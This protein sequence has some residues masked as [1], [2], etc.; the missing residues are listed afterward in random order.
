[1]LSLLFVPALYGQKK[2]AAGL[3]HGLDAYIMKVLQTF[4]VPGAGVAIVKD[5]KP[6]LTKGYG[7]KKMG[8]P[9]AVDELT[10]FAIASNSKA[11]TGT[12]LAMLAEEGKIKWDAPV[13]AYLPWFK[14]SD[15][16]ITSHLSV[17][18]LLVHHS[19]IPAYAGDLMLFPPSTYSRSEIIKRF[20]HIPFVNDFRTTYAYDN[21]LYLV[22]GEVITV[23]SGMPW[24]TFIK[25]RIFDKVGMKTSISKFSTFKDQP[26]ISAAHFRAEGKVKEIPDAY[27]Q[28]M[29]DAGNP[30]GGVL[31]NA[32]DMAQWMITQLDSGRTPL[33]K[34]LY[35]PATTNELW[36][37]VRPMPVGKV[38]ESILPSQANFAGYGLGFRSMNYGRYKLVYHGGKLDGFVSQV[39]MVPELNL[40]ITVLTNQEATGA[41]WSIIYQVLDHYMK[42][43]GF[44]W[45]AGYKKIQDTYYERL[46]N[47]QEKAVITKDP[48]AGPSLPVAKYMGTFRDRLCGDVTIAQSDKG[49]TLQFDFSPQ[50]IADVEHFQRD[51]FIAKFRN[52]DFKADAYL[53]YALNPD[54]TIAEL[55][56]QIIDPDSDLSF[57][58]LRLR[59][60]SFDS[61]ELRKKI[62]DVF[63]KSPTGTFAVAYKELQSGRTF[64][65]NEQEVFHAA[66]TM[67]TPVMI[68]AYK[69]AAEGKFSIYDSILVKNSFSSIVDGSSYSLDSVGDSEH[70]LYKYIGRKLPMRDVI[71]PMITMSS[72]LATNILID[73][74]GAKNVT[75]TMRSLGASKIEVLRGVEDTK[76]F[77][78]G[79]SNTT[80]AYDLMLIMEAIA[81]E[82]VVNKEADTDMLQILLSQ[83]FKRVIGGRLPKDVQVANKTGA[84][85]GV[86]HD[87]GIVYLPDGKKYVI[88]LLSRGIADEDESAETLAEISRALYDYTVG[89]TK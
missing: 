27:N 58:A 48:V 33:K 38:A 80:T 51:V 89:E 77:E 35:Q 46:K 12:A 40:G 2:A 59:P 75:Q 15:D 82:K 37:I 16:F 22:A 5:G 67:K 61:A 1:M 25:T 3:P 18:D 55:K 13:T 24:E 60:V 19:G 65:W 44:D 71:F 78:K 69:Q 43:P 88:V 79:L 45:I 6:L 66:S 9:D 36:K 30:A 87:S 73:I 68:E 41:Y 31:S 23:A 54:M 81:N 10:L 11:F 84:F 49:I 42:N 63:K 57:S 56:L 85:A 47:L 29:G 14:T 8:A 26:N 64:F 21:I 52:R 28:T 32:N 70:T 17:R 83:H 4:E 76:A 39:V 53:A 62:T 86:R 50:L 7:V 72:N 34:V 74:L 20:R